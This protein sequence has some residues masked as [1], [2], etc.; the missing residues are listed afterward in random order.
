MLIVICFQA[1]LRFHKQMNPHSWVYKKRLHLQQHVHCDLRVYFVVMVHCRIVSP[2]SKHKLI[3]CQSC[4][5]FLQWLLLYKT[6]YLVD[7]P[8]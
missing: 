7:M 6:Q 1:T 2:F 4:H 3:G 5:H 8:I